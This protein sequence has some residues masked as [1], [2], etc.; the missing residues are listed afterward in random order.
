ML[1]TFFFSTNKSNE[2]IRVPKPLIG[3][4]SKVCE[5]QAIPGTGCNATRAISPM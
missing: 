4:P 5:Q 2:T 1:I 3:H